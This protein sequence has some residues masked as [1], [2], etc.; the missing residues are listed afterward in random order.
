MTSASEGTG[1]QGRNGLPAGPARLRAGTAGNALGRFDEAF[2]PEEPAVPA[3]PEPSFRD[4]AL[5]GAANPLDNVDHLF[6]QTPSRLWSGLVGLIVVVAAVIVWTC[7]AQQSVIVRG[8]ATVV[9]PE[10]FFVAGEGVTGL[11]TAVSVQAGQ[12]VAT[13]QPLAT[14]KTASGRV[15]IASPLTGAVVAVDVRVGD[16]TTGAGVASLA[17]SGAAPTAVG[18]FAAAEVSSLA[19]GQAVEV[20]VNGF[21]SGRY[22]SVRA[23]VAAVA[24][25]PA[26]A[27]RLQQ[28]T[29]N[30]GLASTLAQEGPL[31]EVTLALE[32]ADN[33]SGVAWTRGSGPAGP[34]PFGALAVASV[35]VE[36]ESLVRKAFG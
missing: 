32:R 19:V 3:R 10:G 5:G 6:R 9:P 20:G 1:P 28:L 18:L 34:V 35:T 4:R 30:A 7:L 26:S 15:T 24:E 25:V 13:G 31:Y 27:T 29:G 17:Q 16:L 23:R 33:P 21:S 12:H 14:V 2:L 22:G 36:R 8:E 11:V